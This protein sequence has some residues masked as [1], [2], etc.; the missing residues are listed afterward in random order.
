MANA[1]A[2]DLSRGIA[3]TEI[4]DGGS[5]VGR[6]G[7]NDVLLV[8]KGDELFAVDAFC[9]HYHGPLAEGAVVGDTVRCPWHHA[10]FDLRTGSPVAAP[11]MQPLRVYQTVRDGDVVRVLTEGQPIPPVRTGRTET[12]IVV[13]GAGAAGS[14]A[15]A[16]L[17]R[18]GFEGRVTLLAREERLPY[19]KPNLSKDYL[20][21]RAQEEWIPLRGAEDYARDEIKLRLGSVVEEI[22]V[23]R[24]QVR[25]ASGERIAFDKLILAT[26]ARPRQIEVPTE[27]PV[28]Y[29]R[30]WADAD[31][32]RAAAGTARE[33]VVIGASFIG[34]ETAASLRELGLG[35]TVV[36]AEERPL[37]RVLGREA[38]DFIRALHESHGV[39]FRLGRR[40][41][42]IRRDGVVLDDGSIAK[43]QLVVAGIG[44][45]PDL[46]LAEKAGLA[47]DRGIVVD[48]YLR[49]SA[50]NVYAA[51][52]AARYP[53]ARSGASIRVEH[54]VAAGRM[55]QAAAR[56]AAGA[57]ERFT[58]VPFFW[59]QHYDLVFAYTG[60][61]ER[62][63]EVQLFGSLEEKNAAIVYSERGRSGAV[64]TLFRDDISLAVEAAMERGAGN[65]EVLNIARRGIEQGRIS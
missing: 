33:A 30:T 6:A 41:T 60:H 31:A 22:D 15:A 59:S 9:T 28:H 26:G 25:L 65:R 20:A 3:V 18:I 7:E 37:E 52:D 61:V 13:I 14:F 4:P 45:E 16:E 12:H 53:D 49:T 55:G 1:D 27:V 10:C 35:V 23:A 36:G 8:R 56:N 21:G 48:E 40:P 42:E 29:L 11:A 34:L 24:S 5:V 58:A 47:I 38:G 32:L 46:T 19:D 17:R 51:G 43:C 62:F 44:V 57:N 64:A 54:W 2:P 63:D 39:R 50:P